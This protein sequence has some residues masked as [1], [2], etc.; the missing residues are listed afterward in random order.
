[1]NIEEQ[2]GNLHME[3]TNL[4]IPAH[5]AIATFRDAGYRNTASAIAELIDNSIEAGGKDI[6]ILVFQELVQHTHRT[7]PTVTKIAVYDNGCGMS[8]ELLGICLQFGNG[9]RLNS[10]K[11]I[12]RFGIGLP[13][14]SVSQCKHVDVYSWQNEI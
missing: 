7:S 1:M 10:R 3:Q 9:T 11:G 4:I 14:A 12:G 6:E 5:T 2:R 13:Q 8:P